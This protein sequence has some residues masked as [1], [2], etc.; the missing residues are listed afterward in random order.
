MMK[1]FSIEF[2][3]KKHTC[4]A[5]IRVSRKTGATEYHV[6]VLNSRLDNLLFG[7][8]TF[9]E[10]NG[11]LINEMPADGSKELRFRT[12]IFQRLN[13]YFQNTSNA[14]LQPALSI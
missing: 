7:Y 5:I 9:R 10:V 8:N 14:G 2:E 12:L 11:K 13:D 1:I 4:F 6:R 3:F